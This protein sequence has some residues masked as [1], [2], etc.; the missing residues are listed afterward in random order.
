MPRIHCS[1]CGIASDQLAAPT[2]SPQFAPDLDT[3]PGEPLRSTLPAWMQLCPNCGYAAP[4]LAYAAELVPNWV[5][6]SDYRSL[7]DAFERHAWLLEQLGYL[8]DAGWITLQAAW[9][10]E[11][12]NDLDAARRCRRKA[13]RL[14]QAS[15]AAGQDFLDTP[16]E[17][18]A[19]AVDILRR[20]GEF[21]AA[22][23]TI[24]IAL[25]EEELP[26]MLEAVL[27]FQT[28]LVQRRDTG[29]HTLDEVPRGPAGE[30]PV[31][32]T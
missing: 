31:R 17:E 7:T 1:V 19:L 27:R 14:F 30:K 23:E 9:N 32:L 13:I 6:T 25:Q 28:G 2:V 29:R 8:A 10:H 15:K 24:R 20:I 3:R 26:E 5:R 12:G 22:A 16:A 18:L 4:D 21:E 11:D